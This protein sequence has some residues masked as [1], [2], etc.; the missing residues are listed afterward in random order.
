[1]KSGVIMVTINSRTQGKTQHQFNFAS[2]L[3]FWLMVQAGVVLGQNINLMPGSSVV[4]PPSEQPTTVSCSFD[5]SVT[6]L[7]KYCTC[8]N[9]GAQYMKRLQKV[10]VMSNSQIREVY[11]GDFGSTQECEFEQSKNPACKL[12]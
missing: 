9:P 8:I 3:T 10:Y 7:E 5:P 11:L 12:N 4:V 1:M 6:V 2:L